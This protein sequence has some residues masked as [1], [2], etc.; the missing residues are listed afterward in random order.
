M[1]SWKPFI[2]ILKSELPQFSQLFNYAITLCGDALVWYEGSSALT[3]LG[4]TDFSQP[5]VYPFNSHVVACMY[6]PSP[7]VKQNWVC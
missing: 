7:S 5:D 2:L 3:A 6:V 1:E 4:S